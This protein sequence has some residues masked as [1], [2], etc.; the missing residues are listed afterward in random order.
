MEA[1]DLIDCLHRFRNN[2]VIFMGVRSDSTKMCPL[3]GQSTPLPKK[4]SGGEAR[5]TRPT[6]KRPK[7]PPSKRH[8]CARHIHTVLPQQPHA[9]WAKIRWMW[10]PI[11]DKARALYVE[12]IKKP[13]AAPTA[14][15]PQDC[16]SA[17]LLAT[18]RRC[19]HFGCSSLGQ[20][21]LV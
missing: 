5:P 10:G 1:L 7:T 2:S 15:F 14:I 12:D 6:D 19:F 18:K 21:P 16:F 4:R 20:K 11:P 17:M 9:R 3:A 8:R 13:A